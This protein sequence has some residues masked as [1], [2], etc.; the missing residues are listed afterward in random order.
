MVGSSVAGSGR[1]AGVLRQGAP[2]GLP[3]GPGHHQ[4]AVGAELPGGVQVAADITPPRLDEV[5]APREVDWD[6]PRPDG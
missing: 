5:A 3:G 4:R 1:L 6:V 2:G